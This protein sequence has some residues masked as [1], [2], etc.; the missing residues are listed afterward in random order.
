MGFREF[1]SFNQALVAK[2]GWRILQS[3]D[4]LVA[5][6]LQARY[7]KN[8][9]FLNAKLGWNPSFIWRSIIW[10]RHV[11]K[12][13]LRWRI[14]DGHNVQVYKEN[15]LLRPLTFRP[16]SKPTL[17]TN[18]LVFELIND[19]NQWNERLIYNHFDKMDA[20]RIVS[21]PLPRRPIKDQL[22]WHYEKRG[23][24][25]VKSGY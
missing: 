7:F 13:G 2:Q 10:G 9:D 12:N 25:T 3:P 11:I 6:V 17:P 4:S 15:W 19:E 14:I 23:Q 20:D 22:L 5:R 24:Y 16:V 18:T 21:I 8:K 1:S